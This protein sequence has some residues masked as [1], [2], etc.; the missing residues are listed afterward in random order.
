MRPN[1]HDQISPLE[2]PSDAPARADGRCC[3]P[4]APLACKI[5]MHP[6]KDHRTYA[7]LADFLEQTRGGK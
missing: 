4:L 1:A 7:T 2:C 6:L 5:Y 3:V